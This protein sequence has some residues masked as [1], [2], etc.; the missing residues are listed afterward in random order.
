MNTPLIDTP[1][2]AL[3]QTSAEPS[4]SALPT[5]SAVAAASA[6][7]SA[8]GGG[9]SDATP[10]PV[11]QTSGVG[12]D[13]RATA[14]ALNSVSGLSLQ[15]AWRFLDQA[16]MGASM[17]DIASVRTSG[18]LVWLNKQFA[19][20]PSTFLPH[21]LKLVN[22][23]K[24]IDLAVF[25]SGSQPLQSAW[26][27]NALTAPDQLRQRVVFAL[28]QL[29]VVS[30][31]GGMIEYPVSAASYLDTLSKHAFGTMKNLL[32]DVSRHPAMG[33]Y[34][35]HL[36]NQRPQ[37]ESH[38]DQNYAREILQL[39]SIGVN[40]LDASGRAVQDGQGKPI[41]AYTGNDVIV[42]SHV[43]TGWSYPEYITTPVDWPKFR[44]DDEWKTRELFRVAQVPFNNRDI[45]GLDPRHVVLMEGDKT[46]NLNQHAKQSDLLA[47]P[48]LINANKLTGT[49]FNGNK[50]KF[51][52][53][54][55]ELGA[56][57]LDSLNAALDVILA[58]PNVA[59]F[60]ARQMIQRLVTSNPS[61]G[62][63]LRAANAFKSSGLNLRI[64]VQT[65]LRD[66]EALNVPSG[67]K[68]GKIREPMLR[69]TQALRALGATSLTGDY[70]YFRVWDEL[71]QQPMTS[72]SVFNFY[73]P[74]FKAPNSLSASKGWVAPELQISNETSVIT[75]INMVRELALL[76]FGGEV[77]KSPDGQPYKFY[78]GANW[79]DT[80]RYKAWLNGVAYEGHLENTTGPKPY[81]QDNDGNPFM[82]RD[83]NFSLSTVPA[84][85]LDNQ[86]EWINQTL[87]GGTMSANLKAS[88][89][90][91][92]NDGG[93]V[94]QALESRTRVLIAA[95]LISPEYIVQ[96]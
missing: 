23:D 53:Q 60:I 57:P 12:D 34:L 58:H 70:L 73:R 54:W 72:P 38:P 17:A 35:T 65:I 86:I 78:P 9:G 85:A 92:G 75:Y 33:R 62:F 69:F 29:M 82:F 89:L 8:C 20:P 1:V 79:N 31:V 3:P 56:T 77:P 55:F 81:L 37:G 36:G 84:G 87:L 95:T 24:G 13:V 61:D 93:V 88:L 52:G 39:F 4:G 80:P 26:M 47:N 68:A 96:K 91:V 14:L 7:L 10:T 51:L 71:G 90:A 5:L 22:A 32:M 41:P 67:E 64:L 45:D 6:L 46:A 28:S 49:I 74:G 40:Q 27:K 83:I 15:Q 19:M 30:T 50:V 21:F 2:S 76:G 59:P 43:F 16:S 42:L 44:R 48:D 18:H 63:V 25:A 66:P 94:N 11:A